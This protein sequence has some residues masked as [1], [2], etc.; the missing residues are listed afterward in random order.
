MCLGKSFKAESFHKIGS[1]FL[2]FF[3]PDLGKGVDEISPQKWMI[4]RDVHDIPDIMLIT[5][6]S[7]I[8]IYIS[9]ISLL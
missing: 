4:D 2:V 6:I 1:G 8:Y 7:H 9:H 5:H 3:R